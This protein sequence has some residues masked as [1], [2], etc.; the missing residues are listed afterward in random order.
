MIHCQEYMGETHRIVL[1]PQ[2]GHGV[3]LPLLDMLIPRASLL[4]DVCQNAAS[5]VAIVIR[6]ES[7]AGRSQFFLASQPTIAL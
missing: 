3:L 4:R 5:L 2:R 1:Y 6:L 7:S